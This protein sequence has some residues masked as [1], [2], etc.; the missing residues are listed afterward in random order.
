MDTLDSWISLGE[1]AQLVVSVV[2][3]ARTGRSKP[4]P[5]ITGAGCKIYSRRL[6]RSGEE[7]SAK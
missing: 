4:L 3:A 5:R 6:S 1:A 7:A 2:M